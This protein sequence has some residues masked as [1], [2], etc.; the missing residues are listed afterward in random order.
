MHQPGH[1]FSSVMHVEAHMPKEPVDQLPPDLKRRALANVQAAAT[2]KAALKMHPQPSA[3][4]MMKVGT[5][6]DKLKIAY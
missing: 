3:D 1:H 4:L 2:V 6:V 5:A